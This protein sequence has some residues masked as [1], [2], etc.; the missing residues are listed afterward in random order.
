MNL[1]ALGLGACLLMDDIPA[2]ET[3]GG[4]IIC[5]RIEDF[6][7]PMELCLAWKTGNVSPAMQRL[8]NIVQALAK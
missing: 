7:M 8:I 5:R 4:K 6:S 3:W 2:L 1:V